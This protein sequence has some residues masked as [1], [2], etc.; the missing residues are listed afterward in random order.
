MEGKGR[1][2]GVELRVGLR[3]CAFACLLTWRMCLHLA[4][5]LR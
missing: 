2:G 1:E 5:T 3:A 4:S